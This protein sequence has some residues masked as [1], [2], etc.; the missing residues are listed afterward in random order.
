MATAKE[1]RNIMYNVIARVGLD[2][3]VLGEYSRAMSALN[4]LQTYNEMNPPTPQNLP[5]EG[6][7]GTDTG[8]ITP[9]MGQSAPQGDNGLNTL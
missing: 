7:A 1:R 5:P 8:Q 6:L 4:G 3:D 9:E 2:G